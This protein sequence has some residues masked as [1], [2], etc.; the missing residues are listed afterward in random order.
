[1]FLVWTYINSGNCHYKFY[2][3]I[4]LLCTIKIDIIGNTRNEMN[5]AKELVEAGSKAII[6]DLARCLPLGS[7]AVAIYEELQSK[8]IE[9]KIQRLEEFYTNLSESV[10]AQKEKINKEYVSKDDFL[11][12]FEEATRYVVL[13]RQETKREKF[14]N[15]LANSITATYTD[16]DKTERYFKIL[17]NLSD[18]ELNILAVLENP[19]HYNRTH[20]MIIPDPV[21]SRY[22]SS[23]SE[24]TASGIL[25][26]LLHLK[27]HEAQE[28]TIV[29]FSNGLIVANILDKRLHTNGNAI[30]V[31]DNLLTK[32]GK[33]FVKYLKG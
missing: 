32:R 4:Y 12:V 17:D 24:V 30:H 28:A 29:L 23:W 21:N 27:I 18:I 7:T 16:Y 26:Q 3:V 14:K 11:D 20:G 15:I 6:K 31:L 1:M 2:Q 10:N 8:Q 19:E 5:N 33:D 25:T 22:Q 13:E 9:R